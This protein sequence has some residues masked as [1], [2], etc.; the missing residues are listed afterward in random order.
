M[1]RVACKRDFQFDNDDGECDAHGLDDGSI[2]RTDG[3]GL[4]PGK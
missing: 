2:E 3:P 4:S 1:Q